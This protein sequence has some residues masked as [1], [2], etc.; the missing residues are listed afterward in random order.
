[1]SHAFWTLPYIGHIQEGL[2]VLCDYVSHL[3]RDNRI[4]LSSF[5]NIRKIF[6]EV[7]SIEICYYRVAVA[8][9][10]EALRVRFPMV[11]WNPALYGPGFDTTSNRNKYQ[12]LLLRGKGGRCLRL[13]TLPPSCAGCLEI[14]EPQPRGI[15]RACPVL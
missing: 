2:R 3:R 14:W 4:T 9:S 10:F 8:H 1:M 5:V 11:Y 12:E 6:Q 7:L 15:L 13:T